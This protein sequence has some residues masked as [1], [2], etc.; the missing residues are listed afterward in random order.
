[1]GGIE[2]IETVFFCCTPFCFSYRP[3]LASTFF[4]YFVWGRRG[5]GGGGSDFIWEPFQSELL[6]ITK[7]FAF[8][9]F[10]L[11]KE[12]TKYFAFCIFIVVQ[13][14]FQLE[15]QLEVQLE[16]SKSNS[17]SNSNSNLNPNSMIRDS[18]YK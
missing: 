6:K 17:K 10:I 16:V 4:V 3:C 9:I 7:Y 12:K 5:E 13:L 8:C 1:M 11:V 15:L 18:R 14:R 2:Q